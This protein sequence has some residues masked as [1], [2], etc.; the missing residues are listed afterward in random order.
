MSL[1]HFALA[2]AVWLSAFGLNSPVA[3]QP[4]GDPRRSGFEFMGPATQAMQ[5]DDALNP[6]MP[7]V[8]QGQVLWQ[9]AA[10]AAERSCASCHGDAASS[11]RGVAAHYPALDAARQGPVNL[12]Q[13]INLCRQNQQQ[14][15]PW[16]LESYVAQQSRGLPLAPSADP[17]QQPLVERGQQRYLQR[18]GQLNLSCAQCHDS[19]V[20]KSL[21]SSLI[22]QGAS[23]RLSGLP[24]GVAN[25]GLAA[26]APA[27]LH[28]RRARRAL[29]LRVAGARGAGALPGRAGQWHGAGDPGRTA[30]KPALRRP[31]S[32]RYRFNSKLH[33]LP[34]GQQRLSS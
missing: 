31:D 14:A 21:A 11:M 23:D 9:R 15:E 3:A 30:L 8:K 19:N 13:H 25:A 16:R 26:A 5:R 1:R 10:G 27:Q 22:L 12:G 33:P 17:R 18:M 6:G 7:W 29:C 34:L 4:P 2:A 20:G 32:I 24:P 28:E